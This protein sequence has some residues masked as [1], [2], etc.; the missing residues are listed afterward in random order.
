MTNPAKRHVIV[1]LDRSGSIASIL[2]DMQG[3]FDTW[4]DEQSEVPKETTISLWQFDTEVDQIWD[5][6]R[7]V[8]GMRF[9]IVPRG[10]TAL[11]DATAQ[12]IVRS[13]E[14]LAAI[15]EDERPDEVVLVIATDGWENRSVEHPNPAGRAY[16]AG[17]IKV[18]EEQYNWHVIYMGIGHDAFTEA[19][20]MGIT[21]DSTLSAVPVATAAAWSATSGSMSRGSA[22]G[23]YSYTQAERTATSGGAMGGSTIAYP[24]TTGG[25]S[26]VPPL[27]HK[28]P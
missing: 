23:D 7:L 22:G 18:Q 16:V 20:S 27:I 26:S 19:S 9:K 25:S 11:N 14:Q 10:W 4:I 8:K 17:L 15:P 2:E 5:F 13:G 24:P 28:I 6:E 12:A 3:G 21:F 1:V